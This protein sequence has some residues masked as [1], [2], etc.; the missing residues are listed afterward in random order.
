MF[1]GSATLELSDMYDVLLPIQSRNAYE[2]ITPLSKFY[3]DWLPNV[4]FCAAGMSTNVIA[5]RL[6]KVGWRGTFID[7]GSVAD[8]MSGDVSRTWIRMKGDMREEYK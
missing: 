3:V 5:L 2:T 8:A 4:I 1:I 7:I 6:Y